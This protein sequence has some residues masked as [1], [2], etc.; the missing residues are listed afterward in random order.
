MYHHPERSAD[1]GFLL[2]GRRADKARPFWLIDQIESRNAEVRNQFTIERQREFRPV[3]ADHRGRGLIKTI[4]M[5]LHRKG[6]T[7]WGGVPIE[8]SVPQIQRNTLPGKLA[9]IVE[10]GNAVDV[11]SCK[12][13]SLPRH[14]SL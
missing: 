4:R 13:A 10:A 12:P 14:E 9:V 1:G 3:I 2:R 8:K 6:Q 5:A 7:E 11:V